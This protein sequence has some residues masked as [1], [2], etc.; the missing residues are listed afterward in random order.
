MKETEHTSQKRIKKYILHQ[1][2][3]PKLLGIEIFKKEIAVPYK[4]YLT[5]RLVFKEEIQSLKDIERLAVEFQ[6]NWIKKN[7]ELKITRI[8]VFTPNEQVAL[9]FTLGFFQQAH[10]VYLRELKQ[11]AQ[12]FM[13]AYDSEE[14][15]EIR[16]QK[17]AE[18]F[19]QGKL[20]EVLKRYDQINER[21]EQLEARMAKNESI[22]LDSG[23]LLK[24]EL[25]KI[26]QTI[27]EQIVQAEETV[28]DLQ[29]HVEEEKNAP[30]PKEPA[31]ESANIAAETNLVKINSDKPIKKKRKY[32]FKRSP[33]VSSTIRIKNQKTV[34]QKLN[35]KNNKE[36]KVTQNMLKRHVTAL[37]ASVL[38]YFTANVDSTKK[39]LVPKKDF[40]VLMDKLEFIDY[41]WMLLET[42]GN[43][44]I[45]IANQLSCKEL[46]EDLDEFFK[47]IEEVSMKATI[48]NYWV[49]CPQNLFVR[50]KGYAAL[51]DFLNNTLKL[52][53]NTILVNEM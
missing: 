35:K 28:N 11:Y 48:F 13:Q 18:P 15:S 7:E 38:R 14:P 36:K 45:L 30:K 4:A 29:E 1:K 33:Q 44:E 50:L 25:K 16:E 23:D 42:A 51:K 46:V 19:L 24:S 2:I 52:S 31:P 9:T 21:M 27:Q 22:L 20:D 8:N 10:S 41:L 32:V 39:R 26:N 3:N 37:E 12:T 5:C 34:H 17:A 40:L 49:Y 47:K 53:G 6:E 43:E